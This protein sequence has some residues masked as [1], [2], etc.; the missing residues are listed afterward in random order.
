MMASRLVEMRRALKSTGS[1]YLHCDQTAG[2][3]IKIVMDA[4]FGVN[5]FRN[6]IVWCYAGG[7]IPKKDYPRK[8][9]T[10][11]RYS[12]SDDYKFNVEYRPYSPKNFG[13]HSTGEKLNL[14]RGTPVNDWWPDIGIVSPLKGHKDMKLGYPTQKPEALLERIIKASSNEGDVVLDTFAGC[15]TCIAVAQRL[16][17][18]WIGIDITAIAINVIKARLKDSCP[19]ATYT[20]IGEPATPEDARRLADSGDPDARYQFQL[21]ALGLDGARPVGKLKKGADKGVDG[22]RYFEVPGKTELIVYS[23]KSGHVNAKDVRDLARVVQRENA[24]IGVLIGMEDITGPMKTEAA[25]A[26]QYKAPGLE[27][28]TYAKVQ[29]YTVEELMKGTK[30]QWPRY[31]RDV[32]YKKAVKFT[33]KE[34]P[35]RYGKLGDS[36]E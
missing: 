27:G 23:V 1:I 25:S 30:V 4:I 31:L 24:A 13:T 16:G 9:D 15:G 5:N 33:D 6:E 14:E 8:H 11:F 2:H 17:R 19:N 29:L 7:G 3:Y 34:E 12:K 28:D 18:H 10:I 22:K 20:V 21:W 35:A 36:E 26:G 32:T